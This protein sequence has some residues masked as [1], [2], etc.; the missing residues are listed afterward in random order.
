MATNLTEEL[1]V[2][3]TA[4]VEK[5]VKSLKDVDQSTKKTEDQFKELGKTIATVFATKQLL[6]FVHSANQAYE[7]NAQTLRVLESTLDA[8]GAAAWTNSKKLVAMADGFQKVTN[9][10]SGAVQSMQ[11]VLLGFKSI[12]GA[13][14]ES[15]SN[16]ILDMATVMKMDLSSAAQVVGKALDD[17]INGL[18][19]LSRQGFAFTEEQKAM[20]QSMVD[21]GNVAGA[22]KVILDELNGTYGGAAKAAANATT[23]LSNSMEDLKAS[24]GEALS[25]LNQA[26]ASTANK[27]ISSFIGMDKSTKTIVATMGV[28]VAATPA[29]VLGIN[30]ISAALTALE[31]HPLILGATAIAAAIG[32]IVGAVAAY[33]QAEKDE[34]EAA[35]KSSQEKRKQIEL[36]RQQQEETQRQIKLAKEEAD[37]AEKLKQ[38][39]A[40]MGRDL[41]SSAASKKIDEETTERLIKLYP[42]LA[43]KV[44]AYK[45]SVEEA[46]IAVKELADQDVIKQVRTL[47]QEELK[48]NTEIEKLSKKTPISPSKPYADLREVEQTKKQK[49][50]IL[51]NLKEIADKE[52]QLLNSIGMEFETA[53]DVFSGALRRT[54]NIVKTE[55]RKIQESFEEMVKGINSEYSSLSANDPVLQ[56]EQLQRKLEEIAKT[57]EQIN[58]Q[59]QI[60]E[61]TEEE[62]KTITSRLD[63]IERQTGLKIASLNSSISGNQVKSWKK[64]FSEITKVDE[65][66]IKSISDENGKILMTAGQAGAKAYLSGF[67]R[68]KETASQIAGQ[69]GIA[70]DI[71]PYLEKEKAE[72]EKT[73]SSLLNID[74]TKIN[75]AFK[76]DD[77][78]IQLLVERVKELKGIL[79]DM[80]NDDPF[81]S[82]Q[83]SM[84]ESFQNILDDTGNFT[85]EESKM[86]AE[87][88]TQMSELGIN[89]SLGGFEAFG[90]AMAEGA[91][92]SEALSAALSDMAEQILSQLPT[93]FLQAGLQLIAQGQW[94]IGLGF[95]AAAG[96]TSLI[97]GYVQGKKDSAEANALGG[98]YG[99]S[100]YHAFA[101]GGAFTNQIVSS[102]TYF[103]FAK[104][105]GFGTGLMGEAGP[106]AIMPLSRGPDGSLGV[107]VNGGNTSAVF[108]M[109]VIINNYSSEEVHAQE[110]ETADGKR[111]LEI[112]IGAMINQHI[113]SGRA[114]KTMKARYGITAQGY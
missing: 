114:D 78:G 98:V 74:P 108:A 84:R 71:K 100:G 26:L 24:I 15:A 96:S 72:I 70:F 113:G 19:S 48:L 60:A 21:V 50:E 52:R 106:E 110:T 14:F 11:T 99:D 86:I 91:S 93:M 63:Y 23:Q 81:T 103:R 43:D 51:K 37:K 4:E 104:G 25:P 41:Y 49:E 111:Q 88:A 59:K 40:E 54:G 33:S 29:V 76:V 85:S 2:L 27:V 30:G 61:I 1:K 8:T 83:D 75:D 32:A 55:T 79:G 36:Q 73:L 77:P 16:A 5:A 89:A 10:S 64:W 31:A 102:P 67:A 47:M 107:S 34:A 105:S 20:I 42:D 45:T 3:V 80:T 7:S 87:L 62:V 101:L 22:Q 109:S 58:S 112:T 57:R 90:Q 17:P 35:K 97:N 82:W 18:G 94:P 66:Q 9:Y 44:K 39:T 65:S 6:D 38:I 53:P 13:N 28:F 69:F 92:A 56:L 95:I 46:A 12:Q 68:E